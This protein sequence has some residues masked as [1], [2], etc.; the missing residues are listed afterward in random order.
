MG[1]GLA[2]GVPIL[3]TVVLF[4]GFPVEPG[5]PVLEGAYGQS[6]WMFTFRINGLLG[7]VAVVL[8]ALVDKVSSEY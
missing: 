7:A 4:L 1:L 5:Q 2:F 8:V 6:A 3:V